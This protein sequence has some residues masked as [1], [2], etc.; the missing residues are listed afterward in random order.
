MKIIGLTGGIAMGKSLVSKIILDQGHV[1]IDADQLA[2]EVV[3]PHS[4]G[5]RAIGRVFGSGVIDDQGHLNRGAL[6]DQIFKD[7]G[8]RLVLER[9]THPL[10]QWRAQREFERMRMSGVPLVFYDA[11]LI[12]EKD[13]VRQFDQVV[14]VKTSTEVQLER[15]CERDKISADEGNSRISSQMPIDQK[16]QQADFVID[17]SGDKATTQTQVLTLLGQL[18][19][20][21]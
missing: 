2:R 16:T 13:L 4:F 19:Y 11:A 10:I 7:S 3:F 21:S 6:R 14:V 5:L 20:P 18:G 1:V 12:Y 8:K 17:N 15:L 9:I